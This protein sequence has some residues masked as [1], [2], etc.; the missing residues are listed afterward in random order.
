MSVTALRIVGFAVA[1][2]VLAACNSGSTSPPPFATGRAA[3][4][5]LRQTIAIANLPAGGKFT[6][7]IGAVDPATH[8]Y[9]LADRT[10]ASLD[11][12]D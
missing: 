12:I 2:T 11:I 5:G 4:F 9:Y 8:H 7:D 3:T 1:G 6:Y 10:N